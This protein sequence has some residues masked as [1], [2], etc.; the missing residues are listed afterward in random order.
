MICYLL[1]W[2]VVTSEH[3]INFVDILVDDT[4]KL[5]LDKLQLD[6]TEFIASLTICDFLD[7]S[8]PINGD[9]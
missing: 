2:W 1:L 5:Q 3:I 9:K 8:A 6:A 4:R 7:S